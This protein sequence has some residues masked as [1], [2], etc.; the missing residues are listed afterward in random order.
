MMIV[1]FEYEHTVKPFQ[2]LIC[3]MVPHTIKTIGS[4][5]FILNNFFFYFFYIDA[6]I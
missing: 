5:E 1:W 3:N 4:I 2:K 6:E